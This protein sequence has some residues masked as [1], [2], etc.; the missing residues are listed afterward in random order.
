MVFLNADDDVDADDVDADDDF[1][2]KK[3]IE[4][5][6]RQRTKKHKKLPSRQ[7]VKTCVNIECKYSYYLEFI[8]YAHTLEFCGILV[9]YAIVPATEH[10]THIVEVKGT[11]TFNIILL[12]GLGYA[13]DKE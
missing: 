8:E 9:C 10:T 5:K 11:T 7:S 6:N 1:F 3:K 13:A 2:T 4:K 12:I